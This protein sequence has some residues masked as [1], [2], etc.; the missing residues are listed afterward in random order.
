MS[1]AFTGLADIRVKNSCMSELELPATVMRAADARGQTS[2]SRLDSH[3]RHQRL[4]KGPIIREYAAWG[5]SKAQ[6]FVQLLHNSPQEGR[7]T[8]PNHGPSQP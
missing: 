5:H 8:H 2:A 1:F 7:P 6:R 4:L 3:P